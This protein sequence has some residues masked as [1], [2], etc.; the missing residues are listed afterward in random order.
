ME[1]R[2]GLTAGVP[3]VVKSVPFHSPAVWCINKIELPALN[4]EFGLS[5]WPNSSYPLDGAVLALV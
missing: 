3:C 1:S 5:P 2:F 4:Y